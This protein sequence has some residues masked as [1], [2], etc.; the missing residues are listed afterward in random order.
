M[1]ETIDIPALGAVGVTAAVEGDDGTRFAGA[2][3]LRH[4]PHPLTHAP[5]LQLGIPDDALDFRPR[6]GVRYTISVEAEAGGVLNAT[7]SAVWLERVQSSWW[8]ILE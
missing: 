4:R 1:S 7:S 6:P 3:I 2:A 5:A 8:F